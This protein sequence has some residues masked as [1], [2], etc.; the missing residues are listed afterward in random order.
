MR[1]SLFAATEWITRFA[2]VNLLWIAF[3][4]LGLGIFGLFPATVAMFTLIRQWIMGNTDDPIFPTFWRTYKR[5]F[6]KSNLFGLFYYFIAIL[7]YVNLQYIEFNQGGFHDIIKI[8]LYIV[9]LAISFTALYVIPTFVHYELRFF[10]VFKNAFLYM[11]L[12]PLHN[13]AMVIGSAVVIYVMY[14]FPGTLFFF[15]AS[16][17]AYIIMGTC[18]HAFQKIEAK[19]E[20]ITKTN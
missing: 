11:I 6:L 17:V 20:A 19:K 2:Y 13:I 18:Y 10:E 1:N 9:M 16:L 5:E 7:F 15:G 12:H 8:P 3:T 14:L 4:I